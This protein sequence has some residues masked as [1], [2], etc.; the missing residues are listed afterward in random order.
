MALECLEIILAHSLTMFK[1]ACGHFKLSQQTQGTI[2]QE[3]ILHEF[4]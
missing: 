4:H 2:H 3:V 1:V